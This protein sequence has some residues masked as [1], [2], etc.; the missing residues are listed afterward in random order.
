MLP[1][2]LDNGGTENRRGVAHARLPE[3]SVQNCDAT[4][5]TGHIAGLDEN[6]ARWVGDRGQ[7][8]DER[9]AILS[10]WH[11]TRAR[12]GRATV[13]P[14]NGGYNH[15]G[16]EPLGEW[17]QLPPDKLREGCRLVMPGEDKLEGRSSM[18]AKVEKGTYSSKK[19]QR[20]VESLY[21]PTTVPKARINGA[22]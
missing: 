19:K 3:K 8:S 14:P 17:R 1:S 11:D 20:Q 21:A 6:D 9:N 2:Q 10:G 18:N 5:V 12:S 7:P 4:V 22:L 15:D 16:G 13:G